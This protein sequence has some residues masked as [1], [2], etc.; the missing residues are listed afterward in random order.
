MLFVIFLF[1]FKRECFSYFWKSNIWGWNLERAKHQQLR[2]TAAYKKS[3]YR[4]LG[5]SG[6]GYFQWVQ[7][8]IILLYYILHLNFI[9]FKFLDPPILEVGPI[10]S[11]AIRP[12]NRLL[13]AS[14]GKYNV[15][16]M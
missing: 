16:I 15:P 5:K 11:A 14:L 2:Y 10:D 8:T 3:V 9:A 12:S 4:T 7:T 6:I 13:P 1:P